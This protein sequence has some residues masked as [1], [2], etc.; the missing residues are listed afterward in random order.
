MLFRSSTYLLGLRQQTDRLK[1]DKDPGAIRL[2]D[3]EIVK[4]RENP[5][6]FVQLMLGNEFEKVKVKEPAN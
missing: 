3:D 6:Y 4:V 1:T 2:I 5:E